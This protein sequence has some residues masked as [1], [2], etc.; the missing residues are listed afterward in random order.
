MR[1]QAPRLKVGNVGNIN[2]RWR[3]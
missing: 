3:R 1:G 2:R